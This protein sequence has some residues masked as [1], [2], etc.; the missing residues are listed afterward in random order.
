MNPKAFAALAVVAVVAVGA[1]AAALYVQ[2]NYGGTQGAGSKIF[3]NLMDRVDSVYS[4]EV[5]HPEKTVHVNRKG[6]GWFIKEA[7]D[8]PAMTKKV[9]KTLL[10]LAQLELYTPMTSLPERWEK[11]WVDDPT[12]KGGQAKQ[13]TLFDK[14]GK[15]IAQAIAGR[16][17]FS[18][19]GS[20]TGGLFIRRANENQ[21]WLAKGSLDVN[22]EPRDW[23]DRAFMELQAN[24]FKRIV[25]RHP[26]GEEIVVS[27]A[28]KGQ[29]NY[30]IENLPA[31]RQMRSTA[32]AD[33]YATTFSGFRVDDVVSAANKQ[34]PADK[35]ITADYETFDGLTVKTRLYIEDK[36]HWVTFEAV[37]APNAQANEADKIDPVKDAEQINQAAKGW[38]FDVSDYRLSALKKTMETMLQEKTGS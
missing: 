19:E 3:P 20:S 8:Y 32:E 1:A 33:D 7:D 11:L 18:V 37:A 12:R 36:V 30:V 38:V 29:P 4:I 21:S 14:D 10:D 27:K 15:P 9:S 23:F 13:I 28:E 17:K 6:D 2:P 31:G 34:L 35:T 26:G 22:Y 24:R 25:V 16:N 5:I